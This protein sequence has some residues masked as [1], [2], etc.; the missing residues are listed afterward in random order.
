VE[1]AANIVHDLNAKVIHPAGTHQP[2]EP[3][4]IIPVDPEKLEE[5]AK[6]DAP[7]GLD[8]VA[9]L[10]PPVVHPP[11]GT[12]VRKWCQM[13]ANW[14]R[15]TEENKEENKEEKK[16]KRR[17]KGAGD[18]SSNSSPQMPESDEPEPGELSDLE[19]KITPAH[20]TGLVLDGKPL[21]SKA[22]HFIG[23]AREGKPLASGDYHLIII[24]MRD[25]GIKYYSISISRY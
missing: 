25:T 4:K 3:D 20:L 16:D 11:P 12:R 22:E 10:N 8:I 7:R 6:K 17:N 1:L 14:R 5:A 18:R 23:V 13:M 2:D 21:A 19:C 9:G 15:K 24:L